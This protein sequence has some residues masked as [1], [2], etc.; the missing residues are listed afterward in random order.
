[1][2]DYIFRLHHI[3]TPAQLAEGK[4]LME[5]QYPTSKTMLV[6]QDAADDAFFLDILVSLMKT[7]RIAWDATQWWLQ[8][9]TILIC[10]TVTMLNII[11]S[12]VTSM[13]H[14]HNLPDC[15]NT[16]QNL[17]YILWCIQWRHYLKLPDQW[18]PWAEPI[19]LRIHS[20][21]TMLEHW[22]CL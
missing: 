19:M 17:S 6:K 4:N 1:M 10:H 11:Y 8:W 18:K 16:E 14:Y 7:F 13:K 22:Y 12:M 2:F 9:S 3:V 5:S 20:W 15:D 21:A